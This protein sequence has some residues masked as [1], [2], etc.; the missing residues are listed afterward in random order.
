MK[1][2]FST[3]FIC[4]AAVEVFFFFGGGLLFDLSRHYYGAGAVMAFLLAVF[5]RIWLSQDEKAEAL[6]KRVRA[7]EELHGLKISETD[8][9]DKENAQ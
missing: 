4:L 3:L 1:K 7:L 8:L 9:E 2:F 5:L 6:E